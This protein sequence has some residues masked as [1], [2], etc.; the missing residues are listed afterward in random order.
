VCYRLLVK[1]A[2]SINTICDLK[3]PEWTLVKNNASVEKRLRPALSFQSTMSELYVLLD[4]VYFNL[5]LNKFS[6]FQ[7][8]LC[9]LD[10]NG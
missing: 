10:Y 8:S 4:T 5:K 3:L 2:S 1:V 9:L 7:S 6:F